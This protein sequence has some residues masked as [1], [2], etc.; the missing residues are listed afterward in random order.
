MYQGCFCA[1]AAADFIPEAAKTLTKQ[2]D[3]H[4]T[5]PIA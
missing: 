2:E 4:E 5:S 1:F 3:H